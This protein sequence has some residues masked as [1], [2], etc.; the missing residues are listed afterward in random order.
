M[1]EPRS[2]QT[3]EGIGRLTEIGHRSGF[4]GS[5]IETIDK[6]F[7]YGLSEHIRC[8]LWMLDGEVE[9][10]EV[11]SRGGVWTS[12]AFV[13]GGIGWVWVLDGDRIVRAPEFDEPTG[14]AA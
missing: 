5:E 9:L 11:T 13:E 10:R 8:K 6:I 12:A 7:A 14:E 4:T 1:E 2:G 3:R